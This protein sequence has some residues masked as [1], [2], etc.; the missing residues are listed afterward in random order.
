MTLVLSFNQSISN[1]QVTPQQTWVFICP[2]K[3]Q[4]DR[5]LVLTH[6]GSFEQL[7][8]SR[9]SSM[10]GQTAHSTANNCRQDVTSQ[11]TVFVYPG[12]KLT[13]P[14][15]ECCCAH[16]GQSRISKSWVSGVVNIQIHENV[17]RSVF[18]HP[19]W[20]LCANWICKLFLHL[21]GQSAIG[22]FLGFDL[23]FQTHSVHLFWF[24]SLKL[25]HLN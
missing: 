20:V 5:C 4:Q 19:R 22:L 10:S 7:P 3:N 2:Y 16:C 18:N 8:Q 23:G 24:S 11:L 9:I 21:I 1:S 15:H 12:T 6:H 14:A 13:L 25:S 17:I